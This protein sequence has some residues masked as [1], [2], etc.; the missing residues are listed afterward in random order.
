[1]QD[2]AVFKV[3][4]ASSGSN[5]C[6]ELDP[7]TT[8]TSVA[9]CVSNRSPSHVPRKREFS[10][11]GLETFGNFRSKSLNLS[12]A[13]TLLSRRSPRLAGLSTAWEGYS[14]IIG[15]V[16]WRR[17]GI[18]TDLP[19]YSLLTGNLTG[20]NAIWGLQTE[21]YLQNPAVLQRLLEQ[22][23]TH[24]NRDEISKNR[25]FFRPNR[26]FLPAACLHQA[27]GTQIWSQPPA[28]P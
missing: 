1:M 28:R 16:G 3:A 18:R 22:F 21:T 25:E 19:A 27:F 15:P 5:I 23:P 24:V 2:V 7:L 8:A 14:L 11:S 9:Q 12:R 26:D 13:E 17:S 10:G 20:E 6:M 4:W